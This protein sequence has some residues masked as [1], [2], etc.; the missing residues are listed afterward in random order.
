MEPIH[1][2]TKT[3]ANSGP[4]SFEFADSVDPCN[5]LWKKEYFTINI[6]FFPHSEIQLFYTYIAMK[7]H[8]TNGPQRS[9]KN[10]NLNIFNC[11]L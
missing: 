4:P 1:T 11:K 8:K 5:I 3:S 7:V 10:Y 2:I 6:N 9:P